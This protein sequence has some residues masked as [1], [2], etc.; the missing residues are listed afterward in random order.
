MGYYPKLV[1]AI[2][3]IGHKP[4]DSM[5]IFYLTDQNYFPTDKVLEIC[6]LPQTQNMKQGDLKLQ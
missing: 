6:H 4:Y 3:S 2:K 5:D 1:L